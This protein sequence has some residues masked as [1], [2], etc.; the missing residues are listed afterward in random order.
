MALNTKN[1][2]R[3]TVRLIEEGRPRLHV[4]PE[5]RASIQ[6]Y[7]EGI[8]RMAAPLDGKATKFF[9][10]LYTINQQTLDTIEGLRMKAA[11][12]TTRDRFFDGDE[13]IERDL[14]EIDQMFG[15]EQKKMHIQQL[16]H[17]ACI[18]LLS[19]SNGES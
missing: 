5:L 19:S 7:A 16:V 15:P 2:I 4:Q 9:E 8:C 13:R 10:S 12:F 18:N 17:I 14:D 1:V 6:R 11:E 3:E